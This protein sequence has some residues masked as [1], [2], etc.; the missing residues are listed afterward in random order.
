M[1]KHLY[2]ATAPDG[3][4]H[5]RSTAR[6]YTHT[7]VYRLGDAYEQAVRKSI[8]ADV[9]ACH[10]TF[11][12][13]QEANS[14]GDH[15]RLTLSP[16]HSAEVVAEAKAWLLQY[17]TN[18]A[19]I[20]E[21]LDKAGVAHAERVACGEYTQWHNAGWTGRPDLAQKLTG[22]LPVR[23]RLAHLVH[24]VQVL[25]AQLVPAG[26]EGQVKRKAKAQK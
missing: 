14:R 4:I 21:C 2:S 8:E 15:G 3:S 18:D 24:D 22:N 23:T 19:Y 17:P 9:L 16:E 10:G 26:F 5:T 7:V 11:W 1:A 25:Q 12:A 6:T 13:Y 20:T